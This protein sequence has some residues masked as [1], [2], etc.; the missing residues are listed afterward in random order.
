[1]DGA[2]TQKMP[3]EYRREEEDGK[4]PEVEYI[5]ENIDEGDQAQGLYCSGC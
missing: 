4:P 5:P 3:D 2:D 1:M